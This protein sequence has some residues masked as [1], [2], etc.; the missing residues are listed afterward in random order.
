M[1]VVNRPSANS[2]HH[3]LIYTCWTVTHRIFMPFVGLVEWKRAKA[4]EEAGKVQG[5]DC[6]LIFIRWG[7]EMVA[8]HEGS[9]NNIVRA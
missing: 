6:L 4:R 8:V 3:N 7:S 5:G 2:E 1:S 9:D